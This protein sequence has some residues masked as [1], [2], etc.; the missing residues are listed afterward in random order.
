MFVLIL[1]KLHNYLVSTVKLNKVNIFKLTKV[2][3]SFG[4]LVIIIFKVSI[5]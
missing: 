4:L 1:H 3:K 2:V 5:I